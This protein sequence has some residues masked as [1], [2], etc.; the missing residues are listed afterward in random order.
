MNV[1]RC[2]CLYLG[3]FATLPISADTVSS[4]FLQ[5]N[6]ELEGDFFATQRSINGPVSTLLPLSES[7]SAT[8][9]SPSGSSMSA[10]SSGVADYGILRGFAATASARPPGSSDLR[11]VAVSLANLSW[12]DTFVF[13]G[14]AGTAS[15]D[16]RVTLMLDGTLSAACASD[17]SNCQAAAQINLH[18]STQPALLPEI[19]LKEGNTDFTRLPPVTEDGVVSFTNGS[20]V[21]ISSQLL[22]S[23]DAGPALP[24]ADTTSSDFM[25]TGRFFIDVLTPGASYKTASGHVYSAVPSAVPEPAGIALVLLGLGAIAGVSIRKKRNHL[26]TR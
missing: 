4:H 10:A 1:R 5:A 3:M 23:S 20:T 11:A 22:V 6:G 15:V 12:A 14:P 16:A 18:S 25:S 19:V 2:A 13:T 7:L 9:S 17:K 8:G 26:S 21:Q 24:G